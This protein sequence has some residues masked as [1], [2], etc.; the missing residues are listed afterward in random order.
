MLTI[1]LS[2]VALHNVVRAGVFLDAP[3]SAHDSLRY[4]ASLAGLSGHELMEREMHVHV[5]WV[6]SLSRWHNRPAE[7]TKALEKARA[8]IEAERVR[9]D[10]KYAL[11]LK[12]KRA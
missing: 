2:Y 7:E 12:E 11:L 4:A 5:A 6:F 8:L 3:E 9:R 1:D 10:P